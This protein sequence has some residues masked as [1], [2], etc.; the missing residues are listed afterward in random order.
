MSSLGKR[1]KRSREK[2]HLTQQQVA[3]KM[4]I[5]NGTLS[6]YE[7]DYRDPDTDTLNKLAVLYE[8]SV[9]YL[10]GRT[11]D[12]NRVLKE[13][14]RQLIDLVD[15]DLTNEDIMEQMNL[16]VD[17]LAVEKEEVIIFINLVRAGRARAKRGLE[18]ASQESKK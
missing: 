18:T 16:F 9:D 13:Q 2:T 1:L 5:S 8:V 3:D 10:L 6:G 7:R 11:A 12:P 17:G 15:L 14:A 4:G